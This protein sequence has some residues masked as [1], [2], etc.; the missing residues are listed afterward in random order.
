MKSIIKERYK[1]KKTIKDKKINDIGGGKRYDLNGWIY[2]SINGNPFKRGYDY[3]KLI[4]EDMKE[5]QRII[6]FVIYNDYGIKW[7]FFIDA[8]KKY[9]SPKI[10][11]YFPEFYEEMEGFAK[12]ANMN[13][14]EIVAWNNYFTLTESWWSH[15]PEE[16]KIKIYGTNKS[17]NPSSKEGGGS[18]ERCSAFIA[19]GDW[20]KDGK[21]VCA[22]NSFADFIDMY[23]YNS[24]SSICSLNP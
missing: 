23:L 20:T 17:I 9:F 21:I 2:I 13:I 11:K 15:M 1:N 3:G 19:C 18:Q 12:G 8:A 7:D 24:N 5:V 4:K 6:N 22:H 10:K 14:N 16:E